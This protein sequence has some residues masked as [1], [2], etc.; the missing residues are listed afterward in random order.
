MLSTKP[1]DSLGLLAYAA[2]MQEYRTVHHALVVLLLGCAVLVGPGCFTIADAA[3]QGPQ[4]GAP[5]P[6]FTLPDTKGNQ[7]KL[8]SFLGK[9]VILEWFNPDCPFVVYAH[10]KDG[11]L[12]T[13][14]PRVLSDG[15]VWLAINSGAPGKQGAGLE[16]NVAA[17]EQYGMTY[18]VLMDPKGTVGRLYGAITTPHM[19]IIDAKGTLVYAGG[20]D[21][22]PLGRG[23]ATNYV[24]AALADLKAGE[25]PGRSRT[26]PY[27][28][29]V[30]YGRE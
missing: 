6:D 1:Q 29:S 24:D 30:K 23:D 10:G 3:L 13:Q 18:P 21:R 12:T 4:V 27:G 7:V 17:R 9:T 11:P 16:R 28:C 5:A 20:L 19:F 2:A 14:T 22:A 26:K 25:A 8:S 15:V